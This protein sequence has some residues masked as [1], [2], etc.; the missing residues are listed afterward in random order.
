MYG[1]I[2]NVLNDYFKNYAIAS[3]GV[4]IA[5]VFIAYYLRHNFY[6]FDFVFDR[7]A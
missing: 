5:L 6:G 1:H 3:Y 4:Q 7:Y 2:F